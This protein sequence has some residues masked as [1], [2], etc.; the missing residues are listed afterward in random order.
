MIE[1]G[2]VYDKRNAT[3]TDACELGKVLAG[4]G[5]EYANMVDC[6]SLREKYL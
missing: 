1:R 6:I 3:N 2:S 5:R 4:V